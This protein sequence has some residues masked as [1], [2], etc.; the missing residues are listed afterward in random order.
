MSKRKKI[1]S[2]ALTYNFL[3]IFLNVRKYFP[4][5]KNNF[6]TVSGIFLVLKKNVEKDNFYFF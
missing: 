1:F 3:G 2:Y 6:L 5:F 4:T